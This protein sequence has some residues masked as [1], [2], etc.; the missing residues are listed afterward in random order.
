MAMIILTVIFGVTAANSTIAWWVML[1]QRDAARAQ[2]KA[3]P[4]TEAKIAT[5]DGYVAGQPRNR[6][7]ELRDRLNCGRDVTMPREVANQAENILVR[8]GYS[9]GAL[10]ALG[11]CYDE[12]LVDTCRRLISDAIEH[13]D[14]Q[15]TWSGGVTDRP[16]RPTPH[17]V[18][19]A[20]REVYNQINNADSVSMHGDIQRRVALAA[21]TSAAQKRGVVL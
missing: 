20:L 2:L 13:A 5:E 7:D 11:S 1:R 3:V 8:L 14:R 9:D 6:A 12:V 4:R 19:Q 21:V 17:A 10:R 16:S 15:A 18:G